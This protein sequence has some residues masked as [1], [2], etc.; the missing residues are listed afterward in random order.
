MDGRTQ[1]GVR[2]QPLKISMKIYYI[3][4]ILFSLS[5]FK[6]AGKGSVC[7]M[8]KFTSHTLFQDHDHEARLKIPVQLL[9]MKKLLLSR[10]GKLPCRN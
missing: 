5:F 7:S 9:F 10:G 3:V 4:K 1:S 6:L 8:S 2:M